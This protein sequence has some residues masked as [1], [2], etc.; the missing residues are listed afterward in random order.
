[1]VFLYQ[2]NEPPIGGVERYWITLM[3][4]ITFFVIVFMTSDLC[5]PPVYWC[6]FPFIGFGTGML[7]IY[8]E[9]NEIL[10]ILTSLGEICPYSCSKALPLM[11]GTFWNVSNAVMGLTFLGWANNVGDFVADLAI[12]KDGQARCAFSAAFAGPPLYL[13]A[14]VG[15]ACFVTSMTNNGQ[16]IPIFIE[17]V[18]IV[19]FIRKR[20][21]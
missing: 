12:A 4:S 6:I 2:Y 19:L 5:D 21:F 15:L 11:L 20:V 10:N 18:E 1:M 14:S 3:C 16:P 8:I 17:N 9:A 13:L 7:W